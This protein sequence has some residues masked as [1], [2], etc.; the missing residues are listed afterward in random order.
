MDYGRDDE[1]FA[2]GYD[3]GR[4]QVFASATGEELARASPLTTMVTDL[5]FS[6]DGRYLVAVDD[7]GRVVRLEAE[8]LAPV[9]PPRPSRRSRTRWP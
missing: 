3:K 2:Q 1:L 5:R 4:V 8:T 9:G 6:G 7:G